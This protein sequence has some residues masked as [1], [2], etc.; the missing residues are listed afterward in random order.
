MKCD[1]CD[2]DGII[3]INTYIDGKESKISLCEECYKNY[4]KEM[5]FPTMELDGEDKQFKFFQQILSD[6]VSSMFLSSG[7]SP[8]TIENKGYTD[9]TKKCSHCKTDFAWILKNGKFGCDH[10]YQEFRDAIEQ[11]LLQTQGSGEHKGRIPVRYEGLESLRLEIKEKEEELNQLVFDEK[12]E[13]AASV[14]DSLKELKEELIQADGE[15][16]D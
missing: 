2:R 16:N 11:I 12:Y 10:C 13:E 14:R 3:E 1:R 5:K 6:L 9:Q 4:L 7:E 8:I 15:L